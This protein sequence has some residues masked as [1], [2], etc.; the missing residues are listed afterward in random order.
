MGFKKSKLKATYNS[1]DDNLLNDF[2]MPFLSDAISYDRAV[3]FF[4]ASMLTY[5]AQ[6][7]SKFV[8]NNG[9][10]R[11]IIGHQVDEDE[12]DAIKKGE[13]LK[14]TYAQLNVE[15]SKIIN[16]V[17]SDVFNCR[18][19]L[20]S[21]LISTNRLRIKFAIRRRGMYHEK[22]GILTDGQGNKI[23]FQGSANESKMALLPDFN[24][25]SISVYPSWKDVV[26]EEYGLSYETRFERLWNNQSKTTVVVGVPSE[27]YTKLASIYKS[28]SPP[29]SQIETDL[30]YDLLTNNKQSPLLPQLPKKLGSSPYQLKKH[31][32]AALDRWKS[33]DCNGIFALATGAGK[34]IMALH[35][36][37]RLANHQKHLALVVA[38]PYQN[39]AD[40][41]CEVME[42]FSMTAIR[43][44]QSTSRWQL[45]LSTAISDF[46]LNKTKP[47][48]AIVVV[49]NTLSSEVFQKEVQR[50]RSDKLLFVGDECHHHSGEHILKKLPSAIFRVGLSAT[51]WSSK[52]EEKKSILTSYYGGIVAEYSIADALN[53]EVLTPYQYFIH[54]FHLTDEETDEF[55]E[56]SNAIGKM[57]AIR[58]N[59]GTINDSVLTNL[60]MK[61]ARLIGSADKKFTRLSQLLDKAKIEKHTLFYCG[62]GSVVEERDCTE[63]D[64]FGVRDIRRVASILHKHN[65]KSSKFTADESLKERRKIIDNFRL[66]FID[67]MVSIRV[68][69]EG[70]DI[71]V[72]KQAFLLASS[73]NERQ[74]IQRRGRILRKAVGKEFSV[75]HD[76][77][78]LPSESVDVDDS[79]KSLVNS[80]LDRVYEFAHV[81]MNKKE[82]YETANQIADAYGIDWLGKVYKDD[83]G[84]LNEC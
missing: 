11:L 8:L 15:L 17:S 25:E 28:V 53:D 75:I 61:R 52:E 59:S 36:A 47:F 62:D 27:I 9:Q 64:D 2:Y 1:E 45:E 3:G 18:L 51:P 24:F 57:I 73:R 56:L 54:T 35:A 44:Y 80:E 65:W 55:Q 22:I 41:W 74:F 72:C 58:E 84:E 37:T 66:G 71:P 82:L 10:M 42:L 30:F 43:C 32:K 79:L 5:A 40:Q 16:E 4:S 63:L 46:N 12:F 21:W 29:S 81:A 70:I 69:D 50:I 49:N 6:G 14:K 34:T 77:I 7:L 20:I 13:D 78:V 39:L 76:F 48:L 31:Q 68:L 83:I 33:S 19:E 23:V 38:V 67:A 60:F 26:Y